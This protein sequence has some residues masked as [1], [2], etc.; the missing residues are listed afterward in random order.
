MPPIQVMDQVLKEKK[1]PIAVKIIA[2]LI[3]L[4]FGSLM[5]VVLLLPYTNKSTYGASEDFV[6]VLLGALLLGVGILIGLLLFHK[7]NFARIL[8]GIFFIV[9]GIIPWCIYWGESLSPQT[10]TTIASLLSLVFL[11]TAYYLL[12]NKEVRFVFKN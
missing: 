2:S 6:G 4:F 5:V 3:M 1:I 12:L 7:S 11:S 10:I 8:I 9:L